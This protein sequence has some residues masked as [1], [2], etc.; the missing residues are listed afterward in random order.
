MLLRLGCCSVMCFGALGAAPAFGDGPPGPAMFQQAAADTATG[1]P[2]KLLDDR[3]SFVRHVYQLDESQL[4]K[5]RPVLEQLASEQRSYEQRIGLTLH[6]LQLAITLLA[7]N[8]SL[9]AGDRSGAMMKL[10]HQIRKLHA[11]AP[12]SLVNVMRRV[13]P[14]LGKD[15][16]DAARARLKAELVDRLKQVPAETEVEEIDFLLAPPVDLV[17]L[18]RTVLPDTPMPAAP[19]DSTPPV[20]QVP[21]RPVERPPV[22]PVAPPSEGATPSPSPTPPAA[23]VPETRPPARPA[24]LAAPFS[25]PV[26]LPPAPEE[27]E[28]AQR[29]RAIQETHGFTDQQR[30]VAARV[31]KSIQDRAAAH[32]EQR[33]ADYEQ[34]AKLSGAEKDQQLRGLNRRLDQLY[35]ELIRRTEA[36]ATLEQRF[37]VA[38]AA[39]P[40]RPPS[41][42]V[43]PAAGVLQGGS[44]AGRKPA[45]QAPAAVAAPSGAK[46]ASADTPPDAAA[47]SRQED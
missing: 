28:W 6:R 15:P 12:L 3:L 19:M 10:Q 14:L 36:I 26:P 32:R 17:E 22:I 37:R 27:S 41:A 40:A 1:S 20:A 18:P 4:G 47:S 38:G 35:D 11:E 8:E 31:L 39:S 23:P 34:A 16:A 29:A 24:P 5:V 21:A 33:R 25:P 42:P 13:E 7:A 2:E 9:Y 43:P 44:S 30:V 46:S 45:A